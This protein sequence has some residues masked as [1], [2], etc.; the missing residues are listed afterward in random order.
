[1]CEQCPTP[2]VTDH[3]F[4][5]HPLQPEVCGADSD[6]WEC[7]YAEEE[8]VEDE[9]AAAERW[10]AAHVE[11]LEGAPEGGDAIDTA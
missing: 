7:G 2:L 3:R 5:P 8:H 1:M 4:Q 9:R 11:R 10:R 6:G